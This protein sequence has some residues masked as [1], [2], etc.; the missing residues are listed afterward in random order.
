MLFGRARFVEDES[1]LKTKLKL[2]TSL[3]DGSSKFDPAGSWSGYCDSLPS[4]E[5]ELTLLAEIGL[6]LPQLLVFA[7]LSRALVASLDMLGN[8]PDSAVSAT[9]L[10]AGC[11]PDARVLASWMKQPRYCFT[12]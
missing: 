7:C 8:Q 11:I 5:H 6:Q 10:G 9:F 4:D 3:I 1:P 12:L 2:E